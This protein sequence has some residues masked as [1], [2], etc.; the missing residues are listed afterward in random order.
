M[1]CRTSAG[2]PVKML[3][4]LLVAAVTGC[5]FDG[6][7]DSEDHLPS[8]SLREWK[9]PFRIGMARYTM[10]AVDLERALDIMRQVDCHCMGLKDGTL[11]YGA[12]DETI[13]AYRAK[14]AKYDVELVSAGPEYFCTAEQ[15]ERFFAFAK[16]CGFKTV[17]VVPY[18]VKKGMRDSWG[19][20]R[21]ESEAMLDVLEQLVKKYDI[22][23][24]IHNH[25]PDLP[26][27]YPTA[28]AIWARI[29]DRDVRVGLC[30][31]VGHQFRAGGDPAAAIRKYGNRIYEIH[32]KN[33]SAPTKSGYAMQ[34]PRGRMN[35]REIF[36]ALKD[37]GFDGYCLV[38]YERDYRD[39]ALGL[40]ESF[41]YYRG[42]AEG[43]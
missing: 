36:R 24:A 18:A 28:E 23:A 10:Y 42:V 29:K 4:A 9:L 31:D 21:E 11:D 39:N 32:L 26:N 5:V 43:L 12:D 16:R 20:S 25:G 14:L 17:S 40:A 22:R 2:W 30:L 19:S 38:E 1:S 27:L 3:F 41:G 15:A 35:I 34:A 6:Y 37:V 33:V 7:D 8:A 13:A